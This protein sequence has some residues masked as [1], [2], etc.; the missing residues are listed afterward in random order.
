MANTKLLKNRADAGQQLAQKLLHLKGEHLLVLGLPRG[1]I[2]VAFE[3]AR[4]LDA[5][6]E[7]LFVKKIGVPGQKE[8]AIGAVANGSSPE[9][10]LNERAMRLAGVSDHYVKNQIKLNLADIDRRRRLYL[11]DRVPTDP[12][13]RT[14]IL[15]DDGIATGSTIK[16]AIFSLRKKTPARLVVA[17]PVLPAQCVGEYEALADELVYLSAPLR[18]QAVGAHYLDFRQVEDADVAHLLA[19]NAGRSDGEVGC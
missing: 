10:I 15:V 19:R 16:A 17:V 7:P 12:S 11:G 14:V 2:P 4:A 18:L 8:L 5:V 1:G 13:G 3:I 6:L 9:L